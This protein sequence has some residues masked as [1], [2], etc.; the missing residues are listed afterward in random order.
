[1]RAV[2]K[3]HSISSK[4]L[5]LVLVLGTLGVVGCGKVP[6]WNELTSG[7]PEPPP[8]QTV[9]NPKIDTPVAPPAVPVVPVVQEDPA[10]VL[11]WFKSVVPQH[12]NDKALIR[13]TSIKSGLETVTEIDARGSGV[14]DVGMVE[15]TKLP[16]LQSLAIGGTAVSDEGM[17][18]LQKVPSLQSLS[19]NA[20]RISDVGLGH[21]ALLPS[22]KRLEMM[23][24]DLTEADFAAIGRLPALEV[25]VLDRVLELTDPC[26]D[27]LCEATTLKVLHINECIGIT[28]KGMVALAK[29]KGL[30]ELYMDK[31][32]ITGQGFGAA[33][34]KGGLKS[35]KVLSVSSVTINLPGARAINAIKSLESL[36]IGH[37]MGMN[38]V[39]FVELV[40]GLKLKD[41]N[42]QASKGVLGQ[43]LSKIKSTASTLEVL[44]AQDS[45]ITDQGLSF[46]KGH[47]NLKFMDLSNTNVTQG[48]VQQFKKLVPGCEI[49]YA[50]ARY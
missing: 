45:G 11:A 28:D 38:D 16:A 13:L 33:A 24:C 25:L 31:A 22:L 41:L 3:W 26:L 36:N 8:G 7:T 19:L 23:A 15:L 10:E 29:P 35:L 50:G 6:T 37:I 20:S 46:L 14:T 12:L 5:S 34:A 47:K 9:A 1:M 4:L 49:L 17:K 27:L 44:H 21:L 39:F 18:S 42:I 30:E 43:G 2:D 48:G 32:N 40:Q